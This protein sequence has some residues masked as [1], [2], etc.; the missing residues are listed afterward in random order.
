VRNLCELRAFVRADGMIVERCV[1]RMKTKTRVR[2]RVVGHML[3]QSHFDAIERR[4]RQIDASESSEN[5]RRS[6]GY[7]HPNP[8]GVTM[9]VLLESTT[10]TTEIALDKERTTTGLARGAVP[11]RLW[12]GHVDEL[13]RDALVTELRALADVVESYATRPAAT[14][15]MADVVERLR[16][17]ATLVETPGSIE[18][19]AFVTRIAHKIGEPQSVVD[20]FRSE[21]QVHSPPRVEYERA[22]SLR[23]F[24]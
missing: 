18:V 15:A 13:D 16:N 7:S 24:I 6:L 17:A 11:A 20:R 2:E 9:R 1:Y 8:K 19:H 22:Y 14:R 21:L 3:P 10:Q 5:A 23:M 4:M 12:Q